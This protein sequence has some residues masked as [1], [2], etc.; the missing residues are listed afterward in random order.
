MNTN[1]EQVIASS[2]SL[3]YLYS[4]IESPLT[5]A[6]RLICL[7]S[8]ELYS[9]IL[10]LGTLNISKDEASRTLLLVV[11]D[12]GRLS[13]HSIQCG[14]DTGKSVPSFHCLLTHRI[15]RSGIRNSCPWRVAGGFGY[16]AVLLLDAT[17]V[18]F[19]L[20]TKEKIHGANSLLLE[21]LESNEAFLF[22]PAV[23]SLTDALI[24][25]GNSDK[26]EG[27]RLPGCW[28]VPHLVS[29]D[30]CI[31]PLS[32][33]C[34][35]VLEKDTHTGLH[36]L[37]RV[38]IADTCFKTQYLV[39]HPSIL[40]L[41]K[42]SSGLIGFGGRLVLCLSSDFL[43]TD[44]LAIYPFLHAS[45]DGVSQFDYAEEGE[46]L[47]NVTAL[48]S[49]GIFDPLRLV[50]CALFGTYLAINP[51]PSTS[52]LVGHFVFAQELQFDP[53][54]GCIHVWLLD[55]LGELV[56]ILIPTNQSR[57]T[58]NNIL[59]LSSTTHNNTLLKSKA[60][61][62]VEQFAL[63]SVGFLSLQAVWI[64]SLSATCYGGFLLTTG[65]LGCV[66]ATGGLILYRILDLPRNH[67]LVAL[68]P[69]S[70]SV[71]YPTYKDGCSIYPVLQLLRLLTQP[72]T[73]KG[74][75]DA[76]EYLLNILLHEQ[77]F[78]VSDTVA[79]AIVLSA[80]AEVDS[81]YLIANRTSLSLCSLA[82]STTHIYSGP[83][84]K[85]E[86]LAV[87]SVRLHQV[88]LGS[89]GYLIFS[90]TAPHSQLD[91]NICL[92]T[93]DTG[94]DF[95]VHNS[96]VIYRPSK[97]S[98]MH[99]DMLTI[100]LLCVSESSTTQCD[101][102]PIFLEGHLLNIFTLSSDILLQIFRENEPHKFRLVF[103]SLCHGNVKKVLSYSSQAPDNDERTDDSSIDF[104]T[105]GWPLNK[106]R[107]LEYDNESSEDDAG[108][109]GPLSYLLFS[110]DCSLNVPLVS[111]LSCVSTSTA[112]VQI[113]FQTQ[114][115]LLKL[116]INIDP[117]RQLQ[118]QKEIRQHTL[119]ISRLLPAFVVDTHTLLD[120]YIK[121]PSQQLLHVCSDLFLSTNNNI[122]TLYSN[123]F[124]T[125]IDQDLNSANSNSRD[126][127]S[128]YVLEDNQHIVHIY[129]NSHWPLSTTYM[130]IPVLV[131]ATDGLRICY[132]D[133]EEEKLLDMKTIIS[134][135]KLNEYLEKTASIFAKGVQLS[136]DN[137]SH[138]VK[139]LKVCSLSTAGVILTCDG[140]V[141]YWLTFS[142]IKDC[143]IP[144]QLYRLDFSVSSLLFIDTLTIQ[145]ALNGYLLG[146]AADLQFHIFE[147]L[148]G[149]PCPSLTSIKVFAEDKVGLS[150]HGLTVL[151]GGYCVCI[152]APHSDPGNASL[153]V[154]KAIELGRSLSDD[155]LGVKYNLPLAANTDVLSYDY[156]SG[157]LSWASGKSF[158]TID[159]MTKLISQQAKGIHP[160]H[161][162]LSSEVDITGLCSVGQCSSIMCI[163]L[164]HRLVVYDT[165]TKEV[166]T[167]ELLPDTIIR[168]VS[169]DITRIIAV[170]NKAGLAVFSYSQSK[171]KLTLELTDIVPMR[172]VTA[173]VP[174]S[175]DVIVIGDRFGT[176]SVL[177]C[178]VDSRYHQTSVSKKLSIYAEISV[179]AP[180]TSLTTEPRK[181]KGSTTIIHYTLFTGEI[182]NVELTIDKKLFAYL[183]CDQ[184][185][186]HRDGLYNPTSH[187]ASEAHRRFRCGPYSFVNT[188]DTTFLS[189]I[190]RERSPKQD[191]P[192]FTRQGSP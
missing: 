122:L 108:S 164:S 33:P 179:S 8:Q 27:P 83:L 110:Y 56:S 150:V 10:A 142:I 125:D 63:H 171:R 29:L 97:S 127:P 79:S 24:I 116:S 184:E 170:M 71:Q 30:L 67:T 109:L 128:S 91:R 58:L 44:W 99:T 69:L 140:P 162:F 192:Y 124:S 119:H 38:S 104:S 143:L 2:G 9:T 76:P 123:F 147:P 16:I 132:I 12:G 75:E 40:T 105:D 166:V 137:K 177:S 28:G 54:T 190:H 133:K 168:L 182:G 80:P 169:L 154:M 15:S 141:A 49:Y 158:Y 101:T 120:R 183:L 151:K 65:F 121:E 62:Q 55:E 107:K 48:S 161:Y 68:P 61:T 139:S 106:T 172:V 64:G 89:I 87:A 96:T 173:I 23:I 176:I 167:Q 126:A 70:R 20:G 186:A 32:E 145:G 17:L 3:L 113:C 174:L 159:H 42:V 84:L 187:M 98:I 146:V 25:P 118:P 100:N 78:L 14:S 53:N 37:F 13:I 92:K 103:I 152:I 72:V 77:S 131:V 7:A 94:L 153:M 136:F 66:T 129:L 45:R 157:R 41:K 115:G 19:K 112:T 39:V 51:E 36:I 46:L 6:R 188:V 57:F 149:L 60:D 148:E 191:Y 178:V 95:A 185:I 189:R 88:I 59:F 180:V 102:T 86:Q 160:A 163:A 52:S 5:E 34:C 18:I 50:G 11:D 144:N 85:D 135:L 31:I 43:D 93:V 73:L 21:M 35:L 26:L 22:P 117:L 175:P 111:V 181:G 82:V 156:S 134:L 81:K 4:A 155:D 74:S 165:T 47:I 1:E 90:C 130:Y 138:D 114:R